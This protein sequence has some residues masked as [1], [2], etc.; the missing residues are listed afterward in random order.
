ML[1]DGEFMGSLFLGGLLLHQ[2]MLGSVH[3]GHPDQWRYVPIS[4]L[5]ILYILEVL[6]L[7]SL[8]YKLIQTQIISDQTWK[9]IDGIWDK[10]IQEIKNEVSMQIEEDTEK[11]QLLMADHFF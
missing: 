9:L 6:T 1:E 7:I 4:T 5:T 3:L 10:R 2:E 8:T 11:P